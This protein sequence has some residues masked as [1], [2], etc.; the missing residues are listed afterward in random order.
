MDLKSFINEN[1][2][3]LVKLVD[4][5]SERAAI[6]EILTNWL[7]ERI[8]LPVL[9]EEMEATLIRSLFTSAIESAADYYFEVK[10][11]RGL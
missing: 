1:F 6:I 2:D 4:E 11:A 3:W 8:N 9:T 10:A 5:K 7:N